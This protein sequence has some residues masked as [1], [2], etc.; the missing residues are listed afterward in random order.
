[1]LRAIHFL[2]PSSRLL[3]RVTLIVSDRAGVWRGNCR[4]GGFHFLIRSPRPF[5]HLHPE[6]LFSTSVDLSVC[7]L[8]LHRVREMG[9]PTP[10]TSGFPPG[11]ASVPILQWSFLGHSRLIFKVQGKVKC[12]CAASPRLAFLRQN[13]LALTLSWRHMRHLT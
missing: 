12:V 5:P 3:L 1:M 10:S 8:C 2:S 6:F 11:L 13:E 4:R 9:L 7:L